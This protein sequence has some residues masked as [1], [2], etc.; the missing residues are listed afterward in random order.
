M[1]DHR[2][3]GELDSE[4]EAGDAAVRRGVDSYPGSEE[5]VDDLDAV[6]RCGEC[7]CLAEDLIGFVPRRRRFAS[8]DVRPDRAVFARRLEQSTVGETQSLTRSL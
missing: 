8:A 1:L 7:E 5:L 3:L 2:R 4:V 6:V